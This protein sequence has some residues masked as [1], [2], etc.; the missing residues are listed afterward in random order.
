M[1]HSLAKQKLPLEVVES[2]W[3]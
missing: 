1:P 2:V 3:I